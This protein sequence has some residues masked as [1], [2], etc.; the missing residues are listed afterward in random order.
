MILETKNLSKSF[1]QRKAV[2]GL[3]LE[4]PEG[5]VYGFLG[6]NGSGKSTT[7]RTMTALILP[8]EGDVFIQGN[9]VQKM[10]NKALTHVGALIEPF[11]F[12]T[13]FDVWIDAF[14]DPIP[15]G[16]IIRKLGILIFHSTLFFGIAAV[17]FLHKDIKT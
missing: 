11:V 15:W 6:P 17:V 13:Y 10:G 3:N 12:V 2:D 1:G 8:D 16:D 5:S 9:S 4:I 14:K 7:I